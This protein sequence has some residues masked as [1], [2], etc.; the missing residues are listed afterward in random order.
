MTDA[1]S[2]VLESGERSLC[3]VYCTFKP[4]GFLKSTQ[5]V[6]TGFATFT[7]KGRLLTVRCTLT[8][9]TTGS[10]DLSTANSLS[11]K[12]TAV[13]K[14]HIVD[15]MFSKGEDSKKTHLRIQISPKAGSGF[16]NQGKN[17]EAFVAMVAERVNE[18]PQTEAEPE[19]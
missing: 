12:K 14:Q 1:F 7:D 5:Y 4:T 10:Y 17:A 9:N 16:P 11:A 18:L 15:L 13:F 6:Q 8:G 3:P 2:E 19:A